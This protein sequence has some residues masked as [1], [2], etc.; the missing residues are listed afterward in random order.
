MSLL[1]AAYRT[2]QSQI[3]KA[4][5]VSAEE[6]PL[7][8]LSHMIQN[9]QIEVSISS[10]GEFIS[11]SPVSKENAKTILPATVESASRVG[12]IFPHPLCDQLK[13]LAPFGEENYTTYLANL[14]KWVNSDFSHPKASAIFT[15]IKKGTIIQDLA[16]VGTIES[17][18]DGVPGDGKIEGTT[19]SKCLAR[20][21]VLTPG[22]A[23][24][25]ACW[26]DK[27]LF[28]SYTGYYQQKTKEG[29]Q[30]LC[31]LTG[32]MDAVCDKHPKGV[33]PIAG[34]AKLISFKDPTHLKYGGRFTTASQACNVGYSSSQMAH[35]ALRWVVANHGV[36]KGGCT[37]LCWNPEGKKLPTNEMFDFPSENAP[38]FPSYKKELL[39]T[40]GG[41]KSQ[42]N[43]TDEAVFA[44]LMA[45]TT[46]RLSVVYYSEQNAIDFINR[47]EKWYTTCCWPTRK[48]I[49]SPSIQRIVENAFGTLQNGFMKAEDAVVA[50]HTRRLYR[51]I[52]EGQPIPADIV[53]ALETKAGNLQIH[54]HGSR[55]ALLSTACAVLRKY[56]NEKKG[57]VWELALDEK[58]TDRSY[59][60]GRLLAVAEQAERITYAGSEE[61]ETN[62]IRLQSVFIQ[63]PIFAWN[64]IEEKLVPYYGK[65][66]PGQRNYY[67]NIM[68]KIAA[69]LPPPEDE[70]L[71]KRLEGTYLLGYYHQRS[72]LLTKN[73]SKN[74]EGTGNE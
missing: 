72:A 15:Y 16:E 63:R 51:C 71:N 19:Y 22:Q 9:A 36:I 3:A 23:D 50:Q 44:A 14:D 27:S 57:D 48:G 60:F 29:P 66:K 62:A 42:L 46:G 31:I 47:I 74:V 10:A 54:K 39:S 56:Y 2:Y 26:M 33:V 53:R 1:Q 55:E 8:P 73:N 37:Y 52:V 13:Y 24:F 68:G 49:Q 7:T 65:M 18:E 59:L 41:Y 67:K 32:Q 11:A 70:S 21:R 34:N 40:L 69:Q 61:R 45:A 4:G 20:F 43:N 12:G 30:E 25:T 35:S 28:E 6:N 38:D 17:Q 5:T 64:L 58:N